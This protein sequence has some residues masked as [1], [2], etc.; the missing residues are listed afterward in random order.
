MADFTKQT[1]KTSPKSLLR[2]FEFTLTIVCIYEKDTINFGIKSEGAVKH[3]FTIHYYF[4]LT[5]NPECDFSEE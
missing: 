1:R 4:L 2:R 3:F 5:K